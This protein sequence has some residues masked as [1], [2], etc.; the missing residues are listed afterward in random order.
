MSD[1]PSG[2]GLLDTGRTVMLPSLTPSWSAISRASSTFA[3]PVN[4]FMVERSSAAARRRAR[5]QVQQA[6]GTWMR[7]IAAVAMRRLAARA[8]LGGLDGVCEEEPGRSGRGG[9]ATLRGGR[10]PRPLP[11]PAPRACDGGVPAQVR[12]T[13]KPTIGTRAAEGVECAPRALCRHARAAGANPVAGPARRRLTPNLATRDS[14]LRRS[15][16]APGRAVA[17]SLELVWTMTVSSVHS[18][19]LWGNTPP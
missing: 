11:A 14:M 10:E 16:P 3:L 15:A 9:D 5:H 7:T 2:C 1:E 17:R 8:R 12:L 13:R 6:A 19:S 4:S 18:M